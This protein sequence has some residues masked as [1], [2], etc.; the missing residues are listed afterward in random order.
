MS[1]EPATKMRKKI[2][3]A[4]RRQWMCCVWLLTFPVPVFKCCGETQEIRTAWREKLAICI[5]IF[6]ISATLFFFLAGFGL[7]IC[8]KQDVYSLQELSAFKDIDKPMV[9]IYG[10]IYNIKPVIDSHV[11]GYGV[12]RYQFVDLLGQDLSDQ[13]YKAKNFNDYCPGL[14]EPTSDWDN[15]QNR[16]PQVYKHDSTSE[17]GAPKPYINLLNRFAVGRVVYS[18]EYVKKASSPQKRFQLINRD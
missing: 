14:P 12:F 17:T 9:A 18:L 11:N 6:L 3:T 4:E 8:P 5:I 1:P 7:I 2:K 13:F 15:Y 10:Q 16:R